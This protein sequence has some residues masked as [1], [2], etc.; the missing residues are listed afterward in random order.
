M[1]ILQI[2]IDRIAAIELE[3]DPPI[4]RYPYRV[5]AFPGTRE[6]MVIQA[7]QVH[8]L[9]LHRGIQPVQNSAYAVVL[10][11]VDPPALALGEEPIE[12]FM[13]EVPNHGAYVMLCITVRILMSGIAMSSCS[14]PKGD[15]RKRPC[16]LSSRPAGSIRQ[17]PLRAHR[18]RKSVV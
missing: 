9:W 17:T 18:D 7:R 15:L 14:S 4:S 6:P 1:V 11:G 3:C 8:V 13:P 5:R 12:P 16:L 10:L 2:H